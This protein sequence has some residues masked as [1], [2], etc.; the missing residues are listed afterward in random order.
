MSQL[1]VVPELSLRGTKDYGYFEASFALGPVQ[2]GVTGDNS[3]EVLFG[4]IY[5][6]LLVKDSRILELY[7]L[8]VSDQTWTQVTS[9][10]PPLFD[11]AIPEGARHLTFAFDQ[12]ARVIVAYELN[13]EIVVTRWDPFTNQYV[14]NVTF[15]GL[16]PCIIM[17]ATVADPRGFPEP[18]R[19][20]Y[21]AGV[22]IIF[23]WIPNGEW[24]ENAISDSDILI[25]YLTPDRL[26][27]RCRA[28]RQLFNTVLTI[29]DFDD[30]VVMDR[31]VPVSA[32]YQLLVSDAAGDVLPE[33]LLSELYFTELIPVFEPVDPLSATVAPENLRAEED[34]WNQ[35]DD[36]E[37]GA[38][39]TPEAV[40]VDS[41][42]L[43]VTDDD[44]LDATVSP[45]A[46]RVDEDTA[47]FDDDDELNATVAPETPIEVVTTTVPVEDDDALD[48]TVSPEAIRV[49]TV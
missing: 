3:Y 8:S 42:T 19:T 16:D 1:R 22:K 44:G 26:G 23:Q 39:V 43:P 27:V 41:D 10:L 34:T 40:R 31:A 11:D 9:L 25:F 18:Y 47:A 24:L 36:D 4:R 14:Q 12:S 7:R 38:T 46:V 30:P 33:M 49:Q 45:E 32:R 5:S 17:D 6:L 20:L 2:V 28:Q 35:P 37:L 15:A 21:M 13:G 29:H 48:A